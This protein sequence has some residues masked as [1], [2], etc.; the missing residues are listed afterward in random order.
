VNE[1]FAAGTLL[2]LEGALLQPHKSVGPEFGAFRAESI[3]GVVVGFAVDVY[4]GVDG[5]LFAGYAWM[6]R[7]CLLSFQG[8]SL[9]VSCVVD[10]H[11][12]LPEKLRDFRLLD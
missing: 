4:H 9:P 12:L 5:F 11:K 3:M 1:A 8:C 6:F 2:L 7:F 10:W